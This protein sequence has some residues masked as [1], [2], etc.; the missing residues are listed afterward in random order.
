MIK[1]Y[2]EIGKWPMEG[3]PFFTPIDTKTLSY[4]ENMIALETVNIYKREDKPEN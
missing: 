4:K 2:K 3:K 1:Y